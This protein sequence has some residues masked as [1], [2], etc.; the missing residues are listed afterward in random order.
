MNW[1]VSFLTPGGLA[2]VIALVV[3]GL[4][5]WL[6]RP[7]PMGFLASLEQP[8]WALP[9]AVMYAIP[10][11]F[12]G[13]AAYAA[14]AA[15]RAGDPGRGALELVVAVL[16]GNAVLNHLLCRQRRIDWALWFSV[17]LVLIAA[18]AAYL[19]FALDRVA[20]AL[21]GLVVVFFVYDAL[22]LT[23]LAK[24]NPEHTGRPR[25]QS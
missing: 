20:G 18:A 8:S 14:A 16:V 24:S 19:V 15:I 2:I 6:T 5:A 17:P 4:E 1:L 7:D 22:W 12:Y 11:F 21:M 13:I 3:M 25:P 9:R 23:G 10:F